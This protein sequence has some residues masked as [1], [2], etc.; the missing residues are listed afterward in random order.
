MQILLWLL[1]VVGLALFEMISSVDNAIV[2][3]EVLS[4]MSARARRWF[5]GWGVLFA[6]FAVRGILPLFIVWV[7][8]P[9]V[10]P[11]DALTATFSS[12]PSVRSAI[13]HSSPVLL[14]GGGC[15]LVFLFLHWLFLE[16]KNYGMAGEHFLSR[17]GEWFYAAASVVLCVLAW[18]AL[19]A[20]PLLAFGA[21]VGSTVFF[22]TLGFK[23]NADRRERSL[24]GS[25][26]SDVSKILFLE[27]IDSTFSIDGVLGAFAFTL[28]VP[29]ILAGNGLGAFL[30][31]EITVRSVATIK[32]Y[33]FLKNG[34]MYS[35]LFLGVIMLLDAFG[36]PIPSW[37]S[38][39]ATFATVGF[40]FLKSRRALRSGER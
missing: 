18:Y 8:L 14:V 19:E 16:P 40:Y 37:A 36:I 23:Q 6:V 17:H 1:T 32:R 12:D 9:G 26:L 2:N 25:G 7:T 33:R 21:V 13:D 38:P 28:A 35:I 4:G 30:V 22:I 11:L 20:G 15:F 34:A 5:L 24:I 10:G 39:L 29:L 27:V 3:A 31:R